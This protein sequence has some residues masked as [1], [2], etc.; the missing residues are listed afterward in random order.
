G[1]K[2]RIWGAF[3]YYK[4]DR[5][6]LGIEEFFLPFDNYPPIFTVK[7]FEDVFS[8]KLTETSKDLKKIANELA[9]INGTIKSKE[10]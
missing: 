4:E 9:H 3:M 5:E 6:Q 2:H 7:T 10:E 1:R 8:D